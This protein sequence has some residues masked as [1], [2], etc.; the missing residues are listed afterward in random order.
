MSDPL[1]R[2][3]NYADVFDAYKA[4]RLFLKFA[5]FHHLINSLP[6]EGKTMTQCLL[7]F[8]SW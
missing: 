4:P 1:T 2:V 6:E 7:D 3:E 5:R 8:L